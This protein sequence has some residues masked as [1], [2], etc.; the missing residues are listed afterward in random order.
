MNSSS[1]ID[2]PVLSK[3]VSASPRDESSLLNKYHQTKDLAHLLNLYRPYMHLVYGLAFKFVH[4]PQQSQEIVY[5]VFKKLIKEVKNQKIRVFSSWLYTLSREFCQKWRARDSSDEEQILAL[6]GTSKTPI[7]F[8]DEGDEDFEEE[9]SSMEDEISDLKKEQEK[10]LELF[11]NQQKCFQEI[12][13]ITGWDVALI[14]R[15]IRNAKRRINIYQ[16]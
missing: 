13:D 1:W 6:G 7:T 3:W 9:I 16:D 8:F 12:A 4:E 5:C 14:K 2:K 10:C 15:H 11:F